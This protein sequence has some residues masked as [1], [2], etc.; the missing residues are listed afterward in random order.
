M[1]YF[2]L[3]TFY[4][5]ALHWWIWWSKRYQNRYQKGIIF[6]YPVRHGVMSPDAAQ[7]EMNRISWVN[8][9]PK[10]LW[11][12]IS[13]PSW[14]QYL[15]TTKRRF[16]RQEPGAVDCEDY[17]FWAAAVINAGYSPVVVTVA[18]IDKNNKAGGHSVCACKESYKWLHVGNWGKSVLCGGT[19]ADVAKDVY[20]R[21]GGVKLIGWAVASRDMELLQVNK[22][23]EVA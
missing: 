22:S 17:A 20:S 3:R 4:W 1:K 6:Q 7:T 21:S 10:E 11:D 18:W 13:H 9:G 15:L 12:A 19:L 2:L 16:N 8:D 5:F 23:F 14:F